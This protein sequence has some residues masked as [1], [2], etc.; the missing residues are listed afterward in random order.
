MESRRVFFV[1]QVTLLGHIGHLKVDFHHGTPEHLKW[2][3]NKLHPWKANMEKDERSNGFFC[4]WKKSC[5]SWFGEFPIFF[6]GL[7]IPGGWEWDFWSINR[8]KIFLRFG[9]EHGVSAGNLPVM[10]GAW[11]I[12][13]LLREIREAAQEVPRGVAFD[14]V[15]VYL[16]D[17]PRYRTWLGSP[18]IISHKKA[19]WKGNNPS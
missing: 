1:A 7:Y 18:L 3:T 9:V 11:S 16:E 6:R 19:I 15:W 10:S 2:N 13:A 12:W 17:H 14:V 5:T 4:W 8:I